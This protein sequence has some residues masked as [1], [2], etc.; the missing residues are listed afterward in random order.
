MCCMRTNPSHPRNTKQRRERERER[1]RTAGSLVRSAGYRGLCASDCCN[2]SFSMTTCIPGD[3]KTRAHVGQCFKVFFR[4]YDV[5]SLLVSSS[6]RL[7]W[8][9]Q[10]RALLWEAV[11][12][13][14]EHQKLHLVPYVVQFPWICAYSGKLCWRKQCKK[15]LSGPRSPNRAT[16][17]VFKRGGT[18]LDQSPGPLICLHLLRKE[19]ISARKERRKNAPRH[20]RANVQPPVLSAPCVWAFKSLYV[21]LLLLRPL[22]HCFASRHVLWTHL[23]AS[24]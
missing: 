20:M 1:Q 10:G 7:D 22:V 8:P 12:K 19:G 3:W 23:K 2:Q 6:S 5:A 18:E 24:E 14:G 9:F 17:T 4:L 13:R 16:F 21:S 15:G 11:G